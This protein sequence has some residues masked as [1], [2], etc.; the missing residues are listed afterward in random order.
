LSIAASPTVARDVKILGLVSAGHFLSHFY[1]IC[2]PPVFLF[3]KDDLGISFAALGLLMSVRSLVS[4]GMQLPAGMLVDRIGAKPVLLGGMILMAGATGLVAITP[5]YWVL[6][7]LS[8]VMSLGNAVFHPTDYA[9]LNSS[10]ARSWV[11]RA[12]S[13]HTFAGQ[14]GTAVAPA[15]VLMLTHFWDWR[16]AQAI[17]GV[18]GFIV[19]AGMALQWTNMHDDSIPQRKKR[20]EPDAAPE[21]NHWAV[22]FSRPMLIMSLFFTMTALQSGGMQTFFVTGLTALQGVSAEAAGAALS[23]YLLASAGGV[24]LGGVLADFTRRH[25]LTSGAAFAISALILLLVVLFPPGNLMLILLMTLSGLMQGSIRP[26]RDMMVRAA[27]PPSAMGKAFGFVSSGT[28]VG[29]AVAPVLFGW[30][31]DIG[32]P[33]LVF[34][35]LILFTALCVAASVAPKQVRT[36]SVR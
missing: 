11:G 24:L 31:I 28:S 9:I 7:L 34:Y 17:I 5:N 21:T 12:F 35:L 18:V 29:G 15:I 22:L 16:I 4:G 10:V 25:D 27:V 3:I 30:L 19:L 33:E 20:E 36:V 23:G 2:L 6:M 1:A 32:R 8:I 14:L 26:A 13:I